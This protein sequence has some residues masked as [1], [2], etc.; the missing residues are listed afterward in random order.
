V[1][2]STGDRKERVITQVIMEPMMVIFGLLLGHTSLSLK[3]SFSRCT[4]LLM[5]LE[6]T[7]LSSRMIVS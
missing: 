1:T 2:F 7:L 3:A 6:F 4:V 5:D